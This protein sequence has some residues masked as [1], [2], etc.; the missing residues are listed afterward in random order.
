MLDVSRKSRLWEPPKRLEKRE[1]VSISDAV[2]AE[3]EIDFNEGE[4]V[5]SIRANGLDWD[6]GNVVLRR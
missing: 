3:P 5:F 4:D 6:I 2:L 1:M